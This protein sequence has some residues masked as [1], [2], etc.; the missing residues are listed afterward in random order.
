MTDAPARLAVKRFDYVMVE[1]TKM[2][3]DVLVVDADDMARASAVAVEA[4]DLLRRLRVEAV[5]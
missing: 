5:W 4:I 2:V 3:T 1:N